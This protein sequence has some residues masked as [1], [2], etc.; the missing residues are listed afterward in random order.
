MLESSTPGDSAQDPG[1]DGAHAFIETRGGCLIQG[2]PVLKPQ[3]ITRAFNKLCNDAEI[4][5][6]TRENRQLFTNMLYNA[7]GVQ[8]PGHL[9]VKNTRG[10]VYFVNQLAKAVSKWDPSC[11]VTTNQWQVVEEWCHNKAGEKFG[12]NVLAASKSSTPRKS[13]AIDDAVRLLFDDGAQETF[14]LQSKV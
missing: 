9:K 12:Q 13:N 2:R 4:F 7:G 14:S 5:D 10:L 3:S 1:E 6:N 11:S 8:I